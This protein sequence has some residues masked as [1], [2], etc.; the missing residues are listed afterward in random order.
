LVVLVRGNPDETVLAV[1]KYP[2]N[3][4]LNSGQDHCIRAGTC[5]SCMV[6]FGS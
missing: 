3:A 4:G 6:T 5:A 1:C 2:A